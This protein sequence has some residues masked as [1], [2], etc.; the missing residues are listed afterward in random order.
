MP[1]CYIVKKQ[2]P[3]AMPA[4]R[5][6]TTV[7]TATGGTGNHQQ[8][9]HQHQ[10]ATRQV[11]VVN[12]KTLKEQSEPHR[13][14]AARSGGRSVGLGGGSSALG[15][16]I[17][18]NGKEPTGGNNLV[19][20]NSVSVI[21]GGP[22][23]TGGT[24]LEGIKH[25]P[26][27][28]GKADSVGSVSF[29]L[30]NG[31]GGG[32][33]GIVQRKDDSSGPVSPTEG[34]VAPIY[35]TNISE[36]KSGFTIPLSD[37]RTF[38]CGPNSNS[39]TNIINVKTNSS[40]HLSV[41]AS[42]SAGN[43]PDANPTAPGPIVTIRAAA[44][45]GHGAGTT[46][47]TSGQQQVLL[48]SIGAKSGRNNPNYG[49][50]SNN[51]GP[52]RRDGTGVEL[53][54]STTPS[55]ASCSA[56][57]GTTTAPTTMATLIYA[58][59]TPVAPIVAAAAAAQVSDKRQDKSSLVSSY[60]KSVTAATTTGRQQPSLLLQAQPAN[61]THHPAQQQHRREQQSSTAIFQ[62]QQIPAPPPTQPDPS[63]G[64][65]TTAAIFRDRSIEETEAAHDLLSLSQSLPPLT[66][67][68]V[69]TIL[70]PSGTSAS[71]DSLPLPDPA[72]PVLRPNNLTNGAQNHQHQPNTVGQG[73]IISI[74]EAASAA[75]YQCPPGSGPIS[76]IIPCYELT[77]T[78]STSAHSDGESATTIKTISPPPT[79]PLT[80]PTSE[81]SSDTECSGSSVSPGTS[82]S[83]SSCSS[84]SVF[85]FVHSSSSSISSKYSPSRSSNGTPPA[86]E[87]A[88]CTPTG[89]RA[90]RRPQP[91]PSS[92]VTS[93]IVNGSTLS[94]N[95]TASSTVTRKHKSST[96][97]SGQPAAKAP[98]LSSPS[99]KVVVAVPGQKISSS[100]AAEL[101]TY[102]DL[103]SSDG[104]SKNRKKASKDTVQAQAAAGTVST[105][106]SPKPPGHCPP[107]ASKAD[108]QPTADCDSAGESPS[109]P[110][111]SSN[112]KGK[113]KCPEC[114]KQYATS[115]NLS[116]HKQT[117]RS[118]DS[119]SA[120][121][122]VTCG[123]AYVS[124]PALA[125]HLLTHKLSHSCGVCGKLF[126]RP[127]LLQGHLRSH[128]G[129]KPYGCGHCGKAFADRSNLRA[130][131][132]THST[133]KN[134]ECN[135]CHKTFAL[136]SYLNKH[137]ESAC[138]KDDDPNGNTSGGGENSP[139]TMIGGRKIFHSSQDI[140]RDEYAMRMASGRQNFH[141]DDSCSTTTIDVV[142]ADPGDD[143]DEEDIDIITT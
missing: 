130:H 65:D 135:R 134:F 62:P 24:M 52:N 77:T 81:H 11:L 61:G 143:D 128:T 29:T 100:K 123:K 136:K 69:V 88:N 92:S 139:I 93:V 40:R 84:S 5:N 120:K 117:H 98:V 101:Y 110:N 137:L 22:T 12:G 138:Y 83:S 129:E 4:Y 7:V 95:A 28:G 82:S 6:R 17:V 34:C 32:G 48:A 23:G 19:L 122:C 14:G 78:M 121:K 85:S 18:K 87:S 27:N 59:A 15:N 115:S 107:A 33:A 111:G 72:S 53:L 46:F 108:D 112:G 36:S 8:P 133:D 43:H 30:A 47:V 10:T 37:F 57:N 142:T 124:M 54:A 39:N 26:G 119:Q 71:T 127:W 2:H 60:H 9:Q 97:A 44:S 75:N 3:P 16:V 96:P 25:E 45:S 42:S 68:C 50:S 67:P 113:Y 49:I 31:T 102:D 55:P 64:Y 105:T 63:T 94:A 114:G 35:Y 141:N 51:N 56:A 89:R 109:A 58:E 80:P 132:Q 41:S 79:G 1:R 131:M 106:N 103:I 118:L 116:R 21:S 90:S 13:P 38:K 125:M 126:S 86:A 74:V 91:S 70:H 99:A 76:M 20:L 140:D 104:R 66:A 73:G